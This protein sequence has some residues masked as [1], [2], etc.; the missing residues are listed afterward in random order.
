MLDLWLAIAHHLLAFGLVAMLA[1]E[2]SIARPGLDAA[3]V[4]RLAGIDGGY[5]LAAGLIVA[6]GVARI[7]LG[8]K[9]PAYYLEN[10]WFWA[11]MAAFGIAGLLSLPPTIAFIRWGK[12]LKADPTALP[13][14]TE[15][16]RVRRFIAAGLAVLLV[17]P[18]LAGV[19]ARY[20]TSA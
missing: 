19:M 8:A 17:V 7:Y 9:G 11:K 18:A 2:L 5:G 12:R 1:S 15:I 16:A 13:S 3:G 6:V 10:G 4:K 14:P 20:T